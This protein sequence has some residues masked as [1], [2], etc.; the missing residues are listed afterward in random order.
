MRGW[1]REP[2]LWLR[3]TAI[4]SQ[5]RSGDATDLDLLTFAIEGSVDGPDLFARKAIGW[6]LRQ[7]A[8]SDPAWVRAYVDA[9]RDR[10][11][12]LSVREALKHL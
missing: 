5:L 4:I 7:H 2:D 12:L 11:S 9:N 3:R 1:S 6:A 10:L 8:C